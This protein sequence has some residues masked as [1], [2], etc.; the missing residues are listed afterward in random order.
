MELAS[1]QDLKQRLQAE[2]AQQQPRAAYQATTAEPTG[3][4]QPLFRALTTFEHGLRLSGRGGGTSLPGLTPALGVARVK[5]EDF[6]L[7]VRVQEQTGADELVRYFTEAAR[8]E[9][10]VQV[11]KGAIAYQSSP[12][13]RHRP[14][15]GGVSIG[16]PSVEAGTITCFVKTPADRVEVLSANHVIA[17]ANAG[18]QGDPV[19]QPG[20]FDQGNVDD[21]RIGE[22]TAIVPLVLGQPN[23]VDAALCSLDD[24]IEAHAPTGRVVADMATIASTTDVIKT[25]RTTG[26]TQ[27]TVSAF[28]LDGL[29]IFIAGLGLVEFDGLVEIDGDDQPFSQPGDSGA[30]ITDPTERLCIAMLLG[31]DGGR[32]TWGVPLA[33]ILGTLE[34]SLMG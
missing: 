28:E 17:A 23:R 2:L 12:R 30:L 18:R 8:D 16:H 13:D 9:V 3:A 10:D 7:A 29:L 27:G 24:G 11:V 25:G 33:T 31:G 14:I 15:V 1:V 6:A 26:R 4:A 20:P 22:L 5:D 21:D 19:L 34:V 32:V